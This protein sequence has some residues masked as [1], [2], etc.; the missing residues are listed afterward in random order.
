M[1]KTII[2]DFDGVLVD[3]VNVKAD[4]FY[5]L[6]A[7]FGDA[8]AKQ[9]REHHLQHGGVTRAQ[10]I[11]HYH[12][13]LLGEV[14]NEEDLTMW[15]QRFSDI[16]V[17]GVI[18]AKWIV[19]AL[20]FLQDCAASYTCHIASATPEKELLY[21]LKQ[22]N[23]EHFFDRIYGAPRSKSDN[24][25]RII[26]RS[27]RHSHE[28][29]MIGDAVTDYEAAIKNNIAFVGVANSSDHF[30]EDN[31]PIIPDLSKLSSIL[32]ASLLV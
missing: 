21:I 19:G 4:A 12:K 24:V 32:E 6:Y 3:S 7:N 30:P 10:K 13:S 25:A 28:F 22:R 27:G 5:R 31:F 23:M 20:E 26:A 11:R 1:F 16:V 14:L 15:C 9:V 2:F 8:I 29:V 18:S 17:E